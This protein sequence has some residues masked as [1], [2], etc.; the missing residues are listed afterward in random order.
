MYFKQPLKACQSKL[1]TFGVQVKQ[2]SLWLQASSKSM[3]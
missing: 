2:N 1:R 3:G